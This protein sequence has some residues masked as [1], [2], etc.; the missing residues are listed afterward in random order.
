MIASIKDL[1]EIEDLIHDHLKI[2][3]DKK[4][5]SGEVF[6][7]FDLIVEMLETLP[8]QVW[9][10]P[11]LKWLDPGSGIG[12][13]SMVV[14]YYLDQGLKTWEP[15]EAK[16]RQHILRKMIYMIEIT[17]E[18]VRV[19]ES[20][21]GK[22]TNICNGDFLLEK[23]KWHTQFKVDKFDII[24]GNPPYNKNGMRGKGRS[25]PGLTVIWNKFV[26]KSLTHMKENGYC[27]FFTPNSWTE[28]KSPLSKEML[29]KQIILLRNFDVVDAYK[30][31][32]KKAGSLPLCYYL[33]QN[34]PP[35]KPTLIFD[36]LLKDYVMFDINRFLFIPNKNIHLIKKVLSQTNDSLEDYY[37]FTP[38]KIKKDKETFFDSYAPSHPFPLI[39]YV[40]KKMHVSYSKTYSRL[41]NGRPKLIFPNYSMGYP[42]LDKEGILD[43]GGRSSYA[44]FVENDS[45]DTLKK[46]QDFFLT[47]LA[48]TL[49]NSLKTAQKFLSTRTFSL[50]P[51]VTKWTIPINDETLA[52]YFKL[53]T[54]EKMSIAHQKKQG[55][56][57]LNEKMRDE[58]TQFSLGKYLNHTDIRDIKLRLKSAKRRDTKTFQTLK[59]GVR[60]KRKR[61]TRTK[62]ET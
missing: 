41:Q 21:F 20:I 27:L 35:S 39:N 22:D 32:E 53:T 19:S 55:E 43:V 37:Y 45:V 51:D 9:K 1:K 11:N 52:K 5:E 25:N 54:K 49:I 4:V 61:Q 33:I 50:F 62:K 40:H 57:N 30:L 34:K 46:I 18:N 42:I 60:T 14:F 56:G 38:A 2:K 59:R 8:K 7:P 16:R 23:E 48:L 10:N 17:K 15:N 36:I 31:F 3:Q 58:I 26:D 13:F 47:D 12:N 24:L 28:L 6:T 29:K 44:I